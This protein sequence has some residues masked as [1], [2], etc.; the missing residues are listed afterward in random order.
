MLP[1]LPDFFA[2]VKAF[3]RSLA[4]SRSW[5]RRVAMRNDLCRLRYDGGGSGG[6]DGGCRR[7]S[8]IRALAL[9]VVASALVTAK[10]GSMSDSPQDAPRGLCV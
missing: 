6:S 4:S 10:R 5:V 7:V 3:R 1:S 2:I 8:M 9:L